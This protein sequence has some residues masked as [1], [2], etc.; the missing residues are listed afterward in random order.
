MAIFICSKCS[1]NEETPDELIGKRARCLKCQTL[2]TITEKKTLTTNTPLGRSA[3]DKT[4]SS[5]MYDDFSKEEP[6]TKKV[7]P[8]KKELQSWHV[9]TLLVLLGCIL[10]AQLVELE[11]QFQR[12]QEWE[13]AIKSPGD[14]A[15]EAD[16]NSLGEAGWELVFARRATNYAGTAEYEMIFRR[17][18]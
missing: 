4:D 5:L 18:K 7:V 6:V 8:R 3:S 1:H 16:L 17:P 14:S 11:G 13:Y 15:L 2:G 10:T 9:V 12:R